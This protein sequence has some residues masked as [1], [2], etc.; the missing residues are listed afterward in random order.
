MHVFL[1]FQL[2][3]PQ[4]QKIMMEFEKQSEIMDM[5]EEMMNDAIDDA[6]GDEDDEEE[7]LAS[8]IDCTAVSVLLSYWSLSEYLIKSIFIYGSVVIMPMVS[9]K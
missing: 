4:I 8:E 9:L 3:L 6:M 5:K 7:R 2:K 1:E